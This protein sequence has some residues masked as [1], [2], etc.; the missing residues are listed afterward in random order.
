MTV[1]VWRV[2]GDRGARLV[3]LTCGVFLGAPL[4][5]GGGFAPFEVDG[6]VGVAVV[7]G[8]L[9]THLMAERREEEGEN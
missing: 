5:Q 1:V 3:E 9:E 7:D 8:G 4:V 2:E 6:I